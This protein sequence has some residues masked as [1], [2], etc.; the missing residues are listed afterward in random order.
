MPTENTSTR[1]LAAILFADI[2]GYTAMMQSDEGGTMNRLNHYQKVLSH[3]VAEHKGEIIKNYGDGSLCLF[4]SVLDAVLCAKEVQ[5]TFKIEPKVPLRIGLHL[6][7]VMY[8]ENDIYGNALNISSR[9]ESMGIPGA[10]L[11]SKDVYD[12]VKNQAK[13]KFKSLGSFEFKNV[14]EPMEVFALANEG[15]TVPKREELK[16]KFKEQ[17]ND[18]TS[19]PILKNWPTATIL[20]LLVG[21]ALGYFLL[22][23]IPGESISKNNSLVILPFTI[24]GSAEIQYLGEGMTD[25]LSSKMDGMGTI[26]TV[27]P[28][29]VLGYLRKEGKLRSDPESAKQ[30][31]AKFNAS[32]FILGSVTELSEQFQ[33]TARIY[34]SNGILL[35][36][37]TVAG[38]EENFVEIIDALVIELVQ[39]DLASGGTETMKAGA[40][41]TEN[42]HALKNFLQAEQLKRKLKFVE[43]IDHYK[44]ALEYDPSFAL[45]CYRMIIANGW[46]PN[47][48]VEDKW[49]DTLSKYYNDM[50]SKQIKLYEANI[51][52]RRTKV[53]E[54]FTAYENIY[55]EFP[56]DIDA[57]SWLGEAHYHLNFRRGLPDTLAKK[58]FEEALS[59][60]AQNPELMVHLVN[61]Y[62][63]T[64]ELDKMNDLYNLM[65][66]LKSYTPLYLGNAILNTTDSTKRAQMISD[67]RKLGSGALSIL[68]FSKSNENFHDALNLTM[69]IMPK[70]DNPSFINTANFFDL[71][72]SGKFSEAKSG[73][74]SFMSPAIRVSLMSNIMG[75]PEFPIYD[76]EWSELRKMLSG[77]ISSFEQFPFTSKFNYYETQCI[78]SML[79]GEKDT[80]QH[81]LGII[82]SYGVNP[83]YAEYIK[84]FDYKLEALLA[85]Q[86][87]D[88]EAT[89]NAIE[90]AMKLGLPPN[91]QSAFMNEVPHLRF[92]KASILMK[93]GKYEEA[94][95]WFEN[96]IGGPPSFAFIPLCYLK[97]AQIYEALGQN[98]KVI[99]YYDKFL[100]MYE[101]CDEPLQHHV[102]S[103][104]SS[105]ERLFNRT[106]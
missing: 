46:V 42:I 37:V 2:V 65:T 78:L 104:R 60:D 36:D 81:Y 97:R 22:N 7:D 73:F 5:V 51:L 92:I 74:S 21:A 69:D 72:T 17:S 59:Y 85:Y 54:A 23:E 10:V 34:G 89:L 18:S 68:I 30:V 35:N 11:M 4:N 12:K 101:D 20:I 96:F 66:S 27:D 105:R 100:E 26:N 71:V 64:G 70:S 84:F 76:K 98:E 43:A 48:I 80:L 41:G 103:A 88:N 49:Q 56:F 55:Q 99:V 106:L 52:F 77:S 39:N 50:P 32:K 47:L 91:Q 94:L 19:N 3:K 67:A 33:F 31:A 87:G 86:K 29:A 28:N 79:G 53:D 95:P 82:H 16:G 57:I 14:D 8:K 6:G 38:T 45:A 1:K 62:E 102:E 44:K 40:I 13:L 83:E 75:N 9:I 15:L 90:A 93:Q 63:Q 58:Y 61:I 24:Q 25:L